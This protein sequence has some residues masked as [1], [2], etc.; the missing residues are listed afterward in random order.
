MLFNLGIIASGRMTLYYYRNNN[1]DN[2]KLHLL[3]IY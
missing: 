3:N 2:N 1:N